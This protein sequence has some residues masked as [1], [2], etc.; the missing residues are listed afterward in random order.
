M[1][2]DGDD[3]ENAWLEDVFEDLEQQAAGI[4]LVER[5]AE[6]ADRARS[7][8]ATV[9][10]SSRVHASLGRQVSLTIGAGDVVEGTLARAGDGWCLVTSS[11]GRV[12]WLVRL[13][14]V[15]AAYGLSPRAVPEPVRPA[16][17]RLGFG[18]ALHR[19]AGEA[20]EVL[21]YATSGQRLRVRLRR[22]GADFVE[23]EVVAS[24]AA[25]P[26]PL[27]VPFTAIRAARTV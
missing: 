3:D 2:K 25:V 26:S 7:E 24:G 5:D 17:A 11:E 15:E 16:V 23:A 21:L 22:V 27:V 8:Y 14:A 9:S 6:L 12:G 13:A 19:L 4:H 20:G 1:T 18:S 10:F